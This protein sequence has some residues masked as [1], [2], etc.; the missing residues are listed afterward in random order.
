MTVYVGL[1]VHRKR[2]QVA[3]LDG[4]GAELLN[5][6]VQ[7]DPTEIAA[8]LGSLDAGTS[9]AFEAAYG[10][11]W[12][13][14]LLEELGLDAHLANPGRCKAIASARLK[15]DKVDARM[16]AHLLRADLLAEAWIAPKHVR[17]QRALLRH[18]ISLVRT[19]TA[20]GVR[21]GDRSGRSGAA[22]RPGLR[23]HAAAAVKR[24][25]FPPGRSDG[26]N[27][28]D[29]TA[30]LAPRCVVQA[31]LNTG[32]AGA[33][34][35][36]VRSRDPLGRPALRRAR[37]DTAHGGDRAFRSFVVR[38][39]PLVASRKRAHDA[40]EVGSG[41]WGLVG[42]RRTQI[43]AGRVRDRRRS[44][45]MVWTDTSSAVRVGGSRDFLVSVLGRR[46]ESV[47][48]GQ[49]ASRNDVEAL[50]TGRLPEHAEARISCGIDKRGAPAG[51][52]DTR[53]RVVTP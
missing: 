51:R 52:S 14:E 15:N 38:G 18:R 34:T 5:R 9:V 2:T 42:D 33:R 27:R 8:I 31:L 35:I 20:D 6:N 16:L 17:D 11:G 53:E 26:G 29:A 48:R 36:W 50:R 28:P 22:S 44:Q 13:A 19:R 21:V 23:R 1:D 43:Q 47:V 40:P 10:W 12:L 7:N 4:E 32:A 37:T 3:I 30:D 24:R 41:S 45:P 25:A 46:E 49:G 39:R